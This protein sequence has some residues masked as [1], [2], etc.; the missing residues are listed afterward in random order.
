MTPRK[1]R[2]VYGVIGLVLLV[3]FGIGGVLFYQANADM[4]RKRKEGQAIEDKEIQ[5]LKKRLEQIRREGQ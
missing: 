3:V 4:A 2:M 1:S 5:R